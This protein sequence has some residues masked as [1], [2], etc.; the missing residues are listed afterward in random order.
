MISDTVISG[1]R[2]LLDNQ[3]MAYAKQ[4]TDYNKVVVQGVIRPSLVDKFS[5]VAESLNDKVLY[6]FDLFW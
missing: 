6:S 1:I 4:V 3:E 2:S 5:Q